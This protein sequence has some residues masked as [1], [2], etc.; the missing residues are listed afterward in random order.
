MG[1]PQKVAGSSPVVSSTSSH[2]QYVVCEAWKNGALA[3]LFFLYQ[4]RFNY[5]VC[6]NITFPYNTFALKSVQNFIL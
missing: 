6:K 5:S 1:V 2:Q 4:K 3:L